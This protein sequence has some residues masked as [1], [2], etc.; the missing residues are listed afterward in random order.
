MAG[1]LERIEIEKFNGTNFELWKLKMEDMLLDRDLWTTVSGNKPSGMKQE[2]WNLVDQ[3]ARGMIWLSLVDYV[4]LNIY[5][6]KT[7]HS[8]WKKLEDI[9]QV[10]SLVNKIYLRKKLYSL[11]MDEGSTMENHLNAFNMEIA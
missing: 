3:K 1:T 2:D 10:K 9:Y 5:E 7:S 4:L 8:L 11:K 6:E